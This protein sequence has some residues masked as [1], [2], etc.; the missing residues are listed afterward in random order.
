MNTQFSIIYKDNNFDC[1][2]DR[3]GLVWINQNDLLKS[4]TN[5]GQ[6]RPAR[7]LEEAKEI[8]ELM[9]YSMGY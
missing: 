1:E 7:N 5:N 4:K 2:L 8:A 3:D 6:V 9:L